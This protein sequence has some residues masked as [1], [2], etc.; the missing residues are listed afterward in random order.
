MNMTHLSFGKEEYAQL[1]RAAKTSINVAL[2]TYDA[3]RYAW[4]DD[5]EKDD[6][7]SD[8]VTKA[9]MTYSEDGGRSFKG[10]VKLIAFQLTIDRLSSHHETMD[11]T[12]ETED[13]DR[14]EIEELTSWITPEDEVVG[15]ETGERTIGVVSQRGEM[16][17]IV[18]DLSVQGFQP[19][20]IAQRT[21][22]TPNAVSIRLDRLKKAIT[23]EL[24]A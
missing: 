3:H 15:R 24:A 7:V 2:S 20:E 23:R 10:W 6:I 17:S 4:M 9:M 12:W 22:L 18:Y 16:D 14:I 1:R 19:R 21:G 11:I 13:G 8:A 5:D